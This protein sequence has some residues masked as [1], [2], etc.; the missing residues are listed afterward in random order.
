MWEEKAID[1]RFFYSDDLGLETPKM[2]LERIQGVTLY[3][4]L[5]FSFLSFVCMYTDVEKC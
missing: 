1:G 3:P 5:C 2:E 4:T